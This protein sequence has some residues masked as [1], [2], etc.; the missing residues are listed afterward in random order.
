MDYTLIGI[1]AAALGIAMT[2]LMPVSGR[3]VNQTFI[4]VVIVAAFFV[5]S[6][7]LF[8]SP[9]AWAVAIGASLAAI[10]YRDV[11]RFVRHVVYDVT[12][13]RRRD[14]WY[15]RVGQSLLGGGRSRRRR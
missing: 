10:I 7:A 8:D 9:L 4:T 15:R 1:G 3:R 12:K 2:F 6:F 14:Y 13:Y 11:M 5:A